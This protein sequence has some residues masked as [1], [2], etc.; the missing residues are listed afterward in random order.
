MSEA[1]QTLE[2]RVE[3]LER[4][5]RWLRWSLLI[6]PALALLAG[7]APGVWEG[8]QVVAEDIIL[9]DK[10]GKVRVRIAADLE[11]KGP[12]LYLLSAKEKTVL[13]AGQNKDNGVGFIEYYADGEFKGGIGGNAVKK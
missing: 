10:N 2:A 12:Q 4:Q 8:K 7:A 13:A 1:M 11:G 9:K 6:L 5:N 3:R